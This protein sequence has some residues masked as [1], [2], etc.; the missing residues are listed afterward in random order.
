MRQENSAFEERATQVLGISTDARAT[1][2]AFSTSLGNIPYPVLSDFHPKGEVAK[3]YGVF[4]EERG[5]ANR[6]V[7]VIDKEGIVRFKRVYAD[8]SEFSTDE[9]LAEV[10]KL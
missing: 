2:T 8:M 5:T 7:F 9:I 6:S 1:Q 3:A 4:N 10:D